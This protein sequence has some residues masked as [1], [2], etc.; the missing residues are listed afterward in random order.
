LTFRVVVLGGYGNFGARIARR[1]ARDPGMA[2][3]I[4]GRDP[5]RAAETA[6]EI[7]LECG[8]RVDAA[9]FDATARDVGARLR[10]LE[11][12]LVIH[13]CGPFQARDQG[14][15]RAAL[16]V[17]AHY[18][19]LADA[20]KFVCGIRAIDDA[21]RARELLVVSGASSVPGLSS[22]VIDTFAHEFDALESIDCAI[23][24]GNRTPRGSA[25]V[26][27]VASY[28]GRQFG[29]WEGGVWQ[30]AYGWQR[31]RR[32][33]YPPEVGTRWLADC[34]VPDLELFPE[35]Y[36][37]VQAVRFGAGQELAILHFGLWLLSW[38]TRWRWIA[39]LDTHAERLRRGSEWFARR[40]SDVGAM[41]VELHGYR[42][43]HRL[44]VLWTLVAGH[45]DGPQIP[46][47]PAIV[48]A[49]KLAQ[50]ALVARGAMPCVG[51]FSLDE[52]LRE[53]EGYDV[54]TM[55]ERVLV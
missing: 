17:G 12:N 36:P 22:A 16:S 13:T 19:D 31:L 8:H 55:V 52:C 10:L 54:R 48:I 5:A 37:G 47:T 27:S 2:V 46:C 38:P 44:S 7:A 21:A 35:R 45:G 33:R 6:A 32:H 9:V 49:R 50:G 23:A 29:V 11:P 3:T 14:V 26:A 25:T 15:A 4:V 24:P 53:L 20:R 18:V 42:R 40:G 28:V 34:D 1:L 30:P 41:H 43:A 51:L 39:S